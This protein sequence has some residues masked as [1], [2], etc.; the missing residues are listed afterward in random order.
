[1]N[2]Q[3]AYFCLLTLLLPPFKNIKVFLKYYI[4]D[5]L[6]DKMRAFQDAVVKSQKHVRRFL[7]MLKLK[8]LRKI[9]M[10]RL[11]RIRREEE[12]KKKKKGRKK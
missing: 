11:E 1:M 2:E 6:S 3:H 7:A 12:V 8:K 4:T 5:R 9:E 10:E